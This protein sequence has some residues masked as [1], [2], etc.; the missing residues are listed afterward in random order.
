MYAPS[1]APAC[2]LINEK[3]LRKKS[4]MELLAFF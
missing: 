3:I 1:L 4:P 2:A